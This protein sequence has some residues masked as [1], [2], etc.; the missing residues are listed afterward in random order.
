[1]CHR[2][3]TPPTLWAT[4]EFAHPAVNRMTQ[5]HFVGWPLDNAGEGTPCG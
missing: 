1:M 2:A 4:A 3:S 5:T